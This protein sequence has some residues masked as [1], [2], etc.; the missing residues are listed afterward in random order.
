M[1]VQNLVNNSEILEQFDLE[2][3]GDKKINAYYTSW[4]KRHK[5]GSNPK[6]KL[7]ELKHPLLKALKKILRH[8]KVL[9][10]I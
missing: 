7:R 3:R 8:N 9:L 1:K 5:N 2:D 6:K 10:R 4:Y